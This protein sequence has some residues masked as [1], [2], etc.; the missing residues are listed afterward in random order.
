[1]RGGKQVTIEQKLHREGE[2][3]DIEQLGSETSGH[4]FV[5]DVREHTRD[6]SW[7]LD[8]SARNTGFEIH[9]E[10]EREREGW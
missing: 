8:S 6:C 3:E 1:V 2:S 9:R 5:G 7:L 4:L 10:R